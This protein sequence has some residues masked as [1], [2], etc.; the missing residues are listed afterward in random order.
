MRGPL[1]SAAHLLGAAVLIAWM[2]LAGG[3]SVARAEHA[4]AAP[5]EASCTPEWL[6]GSGVW[7]QIPGGT[8]GLT[9]GTPIRLRLGYTH[10]NDASAAYPVLFTASMTANIFLGP[11]HTV[12]SVVRW[13]GGGLS[14]GGI[15]EVELP[16]TADWPDGRARLLIEVTSDATGSAVLASCDFT[17]DLAPNPALDSDADGLLDTWETNGIDVN[18]DGTVDLALNAAPFGA[19]KDK[20]DIFV[21]VDFM[22]CL[23]SHPW[24][25]CA[26]GDTHDDRPVAGAL[27]D[28]VTA[29]ANAPALEEGDLPVAVRLPGIT[30]HAMQDEAVPHING[31]P[32]T[33]APPPS[34]R[35][36]GDVK[37]GAS[38]DGTST[39]HCGTGTG[40][41]FFGTA[42]DRSSPNCEQIL[43]AKLLVFH[44]AVFGHTYAEAPSSSGV[45]DGANDVM[46]TVA[47]WS[48]AAITAAGGLRAAQAGT[49]MHELGHDLRL[50]HGGYET[51]NCKPNYRS[52]MN[53]TLQFP[54]ILPTRPLDYSR[55]ALPDL[56]EGA[57]SEPAGIGTGV[58]G[59]AIFGRGGVLTVAP[60]G[61]AVDWNGGGITPAPGTV[62]A[63]INFITAIGGGQGCATASPG[64]FIVGGSNDW[65]SLFFSFR[66]RTDLGGEFQG[67][68]GPTPPVAPE[69]TA[70]TVVSAFEAADHDVDGVP[71][72]SDNCV[73]TPNPDQLDTDGDG[74]GDACDTDPTPNTA[75]TIVPLTPPP[76][77]KIKD[78]TPFI[79]ATV[80]D[81]ETDLDGTNVTFFVDGAKRTASYNTSSDT[82]TH[83][84]VQL[85]RGQ[86]TVR[87][88]ATDEKGLTTVKDWSFIVKKD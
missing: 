67:A 56:N 28:V 30:L 31:I 84:S 63:D 37:Y 85:A 20:R 21:E 66:R 73:D 51:T 8:T 71:N 64:Q 24:S 39:Q 33:T 27:S 17:L 74:R 26:A 9:Q 78:R 59:T 19:N 36:L 4:A 55:V 34:N 82:L 7:R 44:Y 13:G 65:Q 76:G 32:F 83:Q 48:P 43:M 79:S 54:N 23:P 1:R 46:V 10:N 47:N 60:A 18:H 5:I 52:A 87:V 35:D 69:Q 80:R 77:A 29:F 14:T 25:T 75:P 68:S 38:T 61:G 11:R 81:A 58:G 6:D 70:E 15:R 50:G 53:Y 3:A 2:P 42:A 57:L 88:E 22:G 12:D 62:A 72:A 86:H 40:V 16:T 41:A 49:F 45:S